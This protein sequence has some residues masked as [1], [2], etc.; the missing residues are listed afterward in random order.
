MVRTNTNKQRAD[1][2]AAIAAGT[3][4]TE[5]SKTTAIPLAT[6]VRLCA[7]QVRE[8]K[9]RK[10]GGGRKPVLDDFGLGVLRELIEANGRLTLPELAAGFTERTG[11]AVSPATVSSGMKALGYKKVRLQKAPSTLAPQSSPRYGKEHRREGTETAYPSDL[12]DAEWAV[13][14]PL[15]AKKDGRGRPPTIDKRR[16]M[17]AIFY[18]VRGGVQWRMLPKN[19]PHW[20][21]VWSLFRR[22]RNSGTLERI[23]DALHEGWRVASGLDPKPTAGIVDSQTAKT[24]EKGGLAATTPAR[25]SK[26][27]SGTWSSIPTDF[28]AQS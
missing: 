24:T 9:R 2:L 20:Q 17:D 12:T 27:G 22:L 16:L 1:A 19:F 15:L 3:D 28:H 23:Y 18:Q 13:L 6:L 25:R 7:A 14:E 21:A 26:A 8:P 11:K 10:P 4:I 5:V